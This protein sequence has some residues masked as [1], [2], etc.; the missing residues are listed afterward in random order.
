MPLKQ[1]QVALKSVTRSHIPSPIADCL[2]SSHL[3][4]DSVDSIKL[5]RGSSH[6]PSSNPLVSATDAEQCS[7]SVVATAGWDSGSWLLLS[8]FFP[9]TNAPVL[10]PALKQTASRGLSFCSNST[11]ME[12][13]QTLEWTQLSSFLWTLWTSAHP[14]HSFVSAFYTGLPLAIPGRDWIRGHKAH[15]CSSSIT[16]PH[17]HPQPSNSLLSGPLPPTSIFFN[18][19]RSRVPL[20]LSYLSL[21]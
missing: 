13:H 18:G 16:F 15:Y 3:P 21:Q 6:P 4:P 7:W 9:I 10:F 19:V 8:F 20:T 12:L 17:S 5:H 2:S 14:S 1:L 11:P